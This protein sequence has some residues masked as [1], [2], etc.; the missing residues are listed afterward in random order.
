MARGLRR[1]ISSLAFSMQKAYWKIVTAKPSIFVTAVLVVAASLFLLGGGVYDILEKPLLA[2]VAAGGRIITYYPF[3]LNE[4]FLVES[5]IVMVL[6][7]IGV[8]GFL[9]TYQSTKYAY[10]SRQAYRL[11]LVGCVLIVVAYILIERSLL[12]RFA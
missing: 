2:I 8:V 6:Y 3:A 5:I 7:A 11:L 12:A 9:L 10:R 4:Q 1:R